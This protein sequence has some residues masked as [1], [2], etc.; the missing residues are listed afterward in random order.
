LAGVGGPGV[1]LG[2]KAGLW[3]NTESSPLLSM[4]TLG[5]ATEALGGTQRVVSMMRNRLLT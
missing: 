4:V 1:A 3:G 5:R 2:Y